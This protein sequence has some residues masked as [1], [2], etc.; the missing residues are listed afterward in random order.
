MAGLFG[1]SVPEVVLQSLFAK[2]DKNNSGYLT[3]QDIRVLLVHDLGMSEDESDAFSMLMDVDGNNSI[4]FEEFKGWI[5]GNNQSG[6]IFDPHGK[7]YNLLLK[8]AEYFKQFD[9]DGNGALEG[10]EI[11]RL[12]Q[13]IGITGEKTSAAV[14]AIDRDNNGK[15]SFHEF[16]KWLRWIPMEGDE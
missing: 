9:I 10:H 8:A 16:L 5:Q 7:R 3:E 13:S 12:M 4:S 6:L 14:S 2:Y 15:I 1:E 11:L